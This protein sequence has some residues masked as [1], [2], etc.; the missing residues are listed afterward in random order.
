MSTIPV[1]VPIDDQRAGETVEFGDPADD[2]AAVVDLALCQARAL[3]DQQPG[4]S[5]LPVQ[6]DGQWGVQIRTIHGT[7]F[8][9]TPTRDQAIASV[10]SDYAY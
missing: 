8:R 1:T 5:R 10:L 2:L 9:P 7:E 6:R 3:A 4:Y